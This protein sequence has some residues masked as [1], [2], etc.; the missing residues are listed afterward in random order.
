MNRWL[1]SM[2]PSHPTSLRPA[3]TSSLLPSM[4]SAFRAVSNYFNGSPDKILPRSDANLHPSAEGSDLGVRS[5]DCIRE[6]A[7]RCGARDVK[8]ESKLNFN[9]PL[10]KRWMEQFLT[11]SVAGTTN[12]GTKGLRWL[13]SSKRGASRAEERARVTDGSAVLRR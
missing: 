13:Q 12:S 7:S 9:P 3:P 1:Q 11:T 4:L 2:D 5:L 10:S 8:Q 6:P